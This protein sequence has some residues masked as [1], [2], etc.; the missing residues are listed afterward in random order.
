MEI[1]RD[2]ALAL[3]ETAATIN[4]KHLSNWDAPLQEAKE[5]VLTPR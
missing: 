1:F 3:G 5:K 2:D 4:D